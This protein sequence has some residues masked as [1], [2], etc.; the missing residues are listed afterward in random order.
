MGPNLGDAKL[1]RASEVMREL[2]AQARDKVALGD[3]IERSVRGYV[4]HVIDRICILAEDLVLVSDNN[5]PIATAMC[6]RG[7]IET[8]GVL[9]E[10]QRK[11][12]AAL[13]RSDFALALAVFKNFVFAS[14]EFGDTYSLATPHVLNGIRTLDAAHPGVGRA[15][16]ILCEVVH[17]NWAGRGGGSDLLSVHSTLSIDRTVLAS[18]VVVDVCRLSISCFEQFDAFLVSN[19]ANLRRLSMQK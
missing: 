14:K 13:D 11:F 5:R 16:D 10:F 15:Y 2:L 19:R 8:A 6:A 7:I 3:A 1:L 4:F 9:L 12:T 18:L 17:P